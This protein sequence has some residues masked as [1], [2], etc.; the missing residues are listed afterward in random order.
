MVKNLIE[1]FDKNGN[2]KIDEEERADLKRF[3]RGTDWVPGNFNN[4]F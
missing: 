1:R 2:S 3:I 4:S